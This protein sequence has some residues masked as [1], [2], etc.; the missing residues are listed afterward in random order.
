M[1]FEHSVRVLELQQRRDRSGPRLGPG[2][3]HRCLR[4]IGLS[5]RALERICR[6]AKLRNPFGTPLSGETVM[7]AAA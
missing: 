1:D 6:R 7:L 5:E 2:R 3:I 4:L